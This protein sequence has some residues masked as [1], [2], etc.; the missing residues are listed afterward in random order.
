MLDAEPVIARAAILELD[1]LV[2]ALAGAFGRYGAK[3]LT[4][5]R[6]T[7]FD[8]HLRLDSRQAAAVKHF[9]GMQGFYFCH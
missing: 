1:R 4:D 9:A 2:F 7:P 8:T 6:R 3:K 5:V